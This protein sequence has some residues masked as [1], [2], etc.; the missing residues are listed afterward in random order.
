[1]KY[2]YFGLSIVTL[3]FGAL[4]VAYAAGPDVAQKPTYTRDVAPIMNSK[5]VTCHRP[6]DIGP[7]S[8]RTYD[9]VRPWAKSIAKYVSERSMP[10]WHADAGYGPFKN[11]RSLTETQVA[12]LV[13]WVEQGARQGRKQDLPPMPE[14]PKGE[15]MLGEPDYT[16]SFDEIEVEGGG[17]DL[18]HDFEHKTDFEEDMWVKAIEILPGNRQVVHHVILWQGGPSAQGWLDGWA[19]GNRPTVFPEGTGRVLKKGATIIGDMHY[20]PTETTETDQTRVGLHFAKAGEIEKE[21]TNLWVMNAEFSIPAGDPNY[22]ARSSYT[23]PQSGRILTITPHMHYRGKDFSYQLTY[24]DG[25]VEDLLKVSNYDFNWQTTYILEEPIAVPAGSRIDCVAHWDNSAD[26]S[27]NPDPTRTVR[28]GP[29]SYDEMMIG[30][31][32]YIVDEGVRP[33]PPTVS[34]I[35]GKIKEL[36]E[37]YPGEIFTVNIP[38]PSGGGMQTSALH[39]PREGEGGWHVDLNGLVGKA[40]IYDIVW[41][42]DTFTCETLIPGQ[43]VSKLEGTLDRDAKALNLKMTTPEGMTVPLRATLAE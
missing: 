15:W 2:Q 37:K 4:P 22:E 33:E 41:I 8:L 11:D 16:F 7:M 25:R 12:T 21:I 24:P 10:P 27:S 36:V 38:S 28:F 35:T 19:A 14:F 1:M 43:G 26:N 29:E 3:I 13:R 32:D 34:A 23:F 9:E 39:L 6:G 18:F 5:C 42:G 31:V 20:H 17:P 40:R 30:F